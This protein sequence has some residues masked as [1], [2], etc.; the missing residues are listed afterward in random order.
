LILAD[1]AKVFTLLRREIGDDES[2]HSHLLAFWERE[3]EGER[4]G[5]RERGRERGREKRGKEG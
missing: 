2:V 4:E 1:G 3:R 5:E